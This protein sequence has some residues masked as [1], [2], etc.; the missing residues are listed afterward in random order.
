MSSPT[1]LYWDS[2]A[3][4]GLVNG[5]PGRKEALE[6][7]Y[8]QARRRIVEIWTSTLSIVEANRLSSEVHMPK[9]VPPDS[10]AILD[11]LLF[12]EFVKLIPVDTVIARDARTLVRETPKLQKKADAVHLAS[13]IRW[14]VPVLHTY[15]GNDLLHL[16]GK[17]SCRDGS[18]LTIC[19]PQNPSGGLFDLAPRQSRA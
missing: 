6:A 16:D 3:W 17:F 15:D 13:A 12:Q 10:L 8:E 5:E 2:C 14:S 1:K 7:I 4:L 19:E 11:N 18:L 9:P